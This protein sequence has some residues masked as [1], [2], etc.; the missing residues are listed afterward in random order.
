VRTS[1]ATR[2]ACVKVGAGGTAQHSHWH[3][4]DAKE[5]T[6]QKHLSGILKGR[7]GWPLNIKYF[8]PHGNFKRRN[9]ARNPVMDALILIAEQVGKRAYTAEFL[10]YWPSWKKYFLTHGV[11]SKPFHG[12]NQRPV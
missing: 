3:G 4:V 8:W 9:A 6:G 10:D 12:V 11:K 7:G 5:W 1:Q 2:Y